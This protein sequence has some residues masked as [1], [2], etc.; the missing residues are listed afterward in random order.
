MGMSVEMRRVYALAE[1]IDKNLVANDSR[2]QH[3][4]MIIHEEGTTL[5]FRNSFLLKYFDAQHGEWGDCENPGEW[6]MV[7]AEHHGINVYPV[8]ELYGFQELEFVEIQR[9][10]NDAHAKY[11][12]TQVQC[13]ELFDSTAGFF[14]AGRAADEIVSVPLTEIP[15]NIRAILCVGKILHA[16]VQIDTPSGS[17]VLFDSWEEQ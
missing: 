12:R 2:Y 6:I 1:E 11:S 7:F 4:V 5:F 3:S 13:V 15:N 17:K 10:G 16:K 14:V 8:D 9:W